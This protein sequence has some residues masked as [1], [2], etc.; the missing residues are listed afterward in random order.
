MTYVH[1]FM[2]DV[3][4]NLTVSLQDV[5]I[6][7]KRPTSDTFDCRVTV[8]FTN[9]RRSNKWSFKEPK[10]NMFFASGKEPA[11]FKTSYGFVQSGNEPVSHRCLSDRRETLNL[12]SL[13]LSPSSLRKAI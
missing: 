2:A 6:V 5:I 1:S 3:P 13:A 10:S 11:L 4:R 12:T 9:A 8:D 7:V